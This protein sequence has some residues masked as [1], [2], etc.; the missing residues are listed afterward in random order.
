MF[1]VK[2]IYK[3]MLIK[4]NTERSI[5]KGL[6]KIVLY[7]VSITIRQNNNENVLCNLKTKNKQLRRK[8]SYR[9][10]VSC[11]QFADFLYKWQ[12]DDMNTLSQVIPISASVSYKYS[13]HKG[14]SIQQTELLSNCR[15]VDVLTYILNCHL[16]RIRS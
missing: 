16:W 8:Y 10:S 2:V 15:S 4:Q 6:F 5:F 12:I 14:Y 3:Q 9:Q 11:M 7:Y 1:Y 13:L